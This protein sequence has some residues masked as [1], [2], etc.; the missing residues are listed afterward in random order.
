MSFIKK[1]IYRHYKGNLYEVIDVARHSESLEDMVVYRALYGDF[2]LW[3]RPL[4]MFLQ[5]IEIS[6]VVH[7]RFELYE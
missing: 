3:V 1:G 6:G 4:K 7:K 5:D 2:E